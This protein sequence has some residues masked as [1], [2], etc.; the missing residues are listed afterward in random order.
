MSNR[1]QFLRYD[2]GYQPDKNL[3]TQPPDKGSNVL[4]TS[5][6]DL[7]KAYQEF[8][9]NELKIYKLS[10]LKLDD[11]VDRLAMGYTFE[12]P[13]KQNIN[14]ADLVKETTFR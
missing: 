1:V 13:K 10:G 7:S 2:V 14:L 5:S 4:S 6:T 3:V 12:P 9:E 8:E 11:I